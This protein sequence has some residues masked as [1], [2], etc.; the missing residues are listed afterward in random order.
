M[1]GKRDQDLYLTGHL[2]PDNVAVGALAG[3]VVGDSNVIGARRSRSDPN[4]IR[5]KGKAISPVKHD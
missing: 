5:A 2:M 1:Q 4:I 3:N